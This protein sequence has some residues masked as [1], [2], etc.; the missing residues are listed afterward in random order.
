MI[1]FVHVQGRW[2]FWSPTVGRPK[3]SPETPPCPAGDGGG[4]GV[5]AAQMKRRHRF[6]MCGDGGVRGRGVWGETQKG[7]RT[8]E[9][10]G[11]GCQVLRGRSLGVKSSSERSARSRV[12]FY[13]DL[14]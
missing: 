5:A 11:G 6:R 1:R 9:Q 2:L 8:P 3:W 12:P 13:T 7:G 14:V 10:Q 4:P